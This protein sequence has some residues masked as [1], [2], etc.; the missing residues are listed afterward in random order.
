MSILCLKISTPLTLCTF[1]KLTPPKLTLYSAEKV[2]GKHDHLM[3]QRVTTH[4]N[5][6]LGGH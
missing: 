5:I 6:P 4:K 1:S 2:Q 3:T